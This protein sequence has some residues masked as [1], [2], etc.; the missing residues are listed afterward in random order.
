M[1][2]ENRTEKKTEVK[3]QRKRLFTAIFLFGSLLFVCVTAALVF[4]QTENGTS[5]ISGKINA[6]L[7]GKIEF[8]EFSLSLIKGRVNLSQ[9]RI[10][11]PQGDTVSTLNGLQLDFRLSKLFSTGTLFIENLVLDTPDIRLFLD[12]KN[13]LTIISA[14]VRPNTE[15]HAETTPPRP[16]SKSKRPFVLPVNIVLNHLSIIQGRVQ[17][18]APH[19]NMLAEIKDVDIQGDGNLFDKTLTA[20][21]AI[22]PGFFQIPPYYHTAIEQGNLHA[23]LKDQTVWVDCL[24]IESETATFSIQGSIDTLFSHPFFHATMDVSQFDMASLFSDLY[25]KTDFSGIIHGWITVSGHLGNPEVT[26]SLVHETGNLFV[27]KMDRIALEAAMKDKK[28]HISKLSAVKNSG[29][30]DITA[31]VDLSRMFPKGFI[32]LNVIPDALSVTL[33]LIAKAFDLKAVPLIDPQKIQGVVDGEI[34]LSLDGVRP[35]KFL[36]KTKTDLS[37]KGITIAG[38]SHPVPVKIALD[39]QLKAGVL[40]LKQLDLDQNGATVNLSGQSDLFGQ[41]VSMDMAVNIDPEKAP[42]SNPIPGLKGQLTSHIKMDGTF[43]KPELS[44]ILSSKALSFDNILIGDIFAQASLSNSGTITIDR[45]TVKNKHSLI[46]G[47]GYGELL[48]KGYRLNPNGAVTLDVAVENM[49]LNDFLSKFGVKG[50]I[51]GNATLS[52]SVQSPR[53]KGKI[54]AR[55]TGYGAYSAETLDADFGFKDKTATIDRLTLKKGRSEIV[56]QGFIRPFKDK[57][58]QMT[59]NPEFHIKIEKGLVFLEDFL[60]PSYQGEITLQGELDGKLKDPDGAVKITGKSFNL[61]HQSLDEAVVD[62]EVKNKTLTLTDFHISPRLGQS[63]EGQGWLSLEGD[64]PYEFEINADKLPLTQ[65]DFLYKNAV[66]GYLDLDVSGKGVIASPVMNGT[67]RLTGLMLD[68]NKMEDISLDL[69]VKEDRLSLESG[70]TDL[71]IKGALDLESKDMTLYARFDKTD[72]TPY[73]RMAGRKEDVRLNLDG[74]ITSAGNLDDLESLS[75]K[76][77]LKGVDF[78]Y[79]DLFSLS[80]TALRGYFEQGQF[81]IDPCRFSLPEQGFLD[82]KGQVGTHGPVDLSIAGKIPLQMATP[83]TK[84]LTD[85]SGD[86]TVSGHFEGSVETP[87]INARISIEEAEFIVVGLEQRIDKVNGLIEISNQTLTIH[88]I[89]GNLETGQFSM[90]GNVTL[91]G[92]NAPESL[93][94]TF[95]AHALPITIPDTMGLILNSHLNINGSKEKAIATGE[96]TLVEGTYYKNHTLNLV[97]GISR[98]NRETKPDSEKIDLPFLKNLD[99]DIVIKPQRPFVVDNN[100]AHLEIMSDLRIG[101]T[102]NTPVI[103]GGTTVREGEV[104]YFKNTFVVEKGII[105]FLNPYRTEPILAIK[106][107]TTIGDRTI[108]LDISGPPDNLDCVPSSS[109]R[110]NPQEVLNHEEIL[111]LLVVGKTPSELQ[112]SDSSTPIAPEQMLAELLVSTFDNSIK[113]KTGLDIIQLKGNETVVTNGNSSETSD[114]LSLMVG[115]ELSP[116]LILK[117]SVES[118][119]QGINQKTMAEYKFLEHI[120]LNGFQDSKGNYGGELQLKNEFR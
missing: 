83:F 8:K 46:E 72:M 51:D 89:D 91:N 20:S 45:M 58:F 49:E 87:D 97:K 96:I 17:F 43:K 111:S 86:M 68:E 115:K 116:R 107:N 34:N 79:Q 65:I 119:D 13:R 118:S 77:D 42:S 40:S 52:G 84:E 73:L 76:V 50:R 61:K 81:I 85:I 10:T 29:G 105:D 117:Y 70:V 5:W 18:S 25:L 3:P 28:V 120:L 19:L 63:I 35:R 75:L 21:V 78:R 95:D 80:T 24:S 9:V 113:E 23:T 15:A 11:S 62:L 98:R 94:A 57:G 59:E 14:F 99:L 109:S 47:K 32:S 101:G 53:V 48:S 88:H 110:T 31:N 27:C 92:L 30:A 2:A 60:S 103:K 114:Q 102:L 108:Y 44:L 22:G 100:L 39:G 67:V 16:E 54:A 4:I 38:Y 6:L 66:S 26:L 93:S 90:D 41:T 69:A 106:A 74:E 112:N 7:P 55:D 64:H 1:I 71:S 36:L 12:K 82:V 56:G 37:M 104:F 33:H